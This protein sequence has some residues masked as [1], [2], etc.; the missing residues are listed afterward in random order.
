MIYNHIEKEATVE[1]VISAKKAPRAATRKAL[2]KIN[3]LN[4]N[5]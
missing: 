2:I 4:Y 5:T 3:Y 1:V